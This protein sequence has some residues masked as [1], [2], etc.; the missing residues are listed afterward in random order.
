MGF[1]EWKVFPAPC[2]VVFASDPLQVVQPDLVFVS[3]VRA[4][5]VTERNIQRVPDLVVEILSE[6]R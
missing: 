5:I 2:D 3:N 1:S 6:E 4:N